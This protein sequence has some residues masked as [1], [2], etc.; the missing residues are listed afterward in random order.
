MSLDMAVD[1]TPIADSIHCGA[2]PHAEL[3]RVDQP[4]AKSGIPQESN[5][6]AGAVRLHDV[7]N[8]ARRATHAKEHRR[9]P[10]FHGWSHAQGFTSHSFLISKAPE[11]TLV[12]CS[13]ITPAALIL[14]GEVVMETDT[15]D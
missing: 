8:E 6:S 1:A 2:E 4:V 11:S 3:C 10:G 15:H 5:G 7:L 13:T 9:R 14:L 12:L